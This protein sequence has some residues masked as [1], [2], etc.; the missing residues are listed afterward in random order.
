MNINRRLHLLT[1]V[2]LGLLTMALLVGCD[3]DDIERS[4]GRQTSAA[5]EAEFGVNR[6][7]VLGEWTNSLGQRLVGQCGRQN[8]AYSFKV[9]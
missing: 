8:I 7:P 1:V 6:D 4:L 3:E 5:V 2:A 9:V